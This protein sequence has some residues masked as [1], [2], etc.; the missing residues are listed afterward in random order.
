MSCFPPP[1]SKFIDNMH[2]VW[3]W[4]IVLTIHG[5]IESLSRSSVQIILQLHWYFEHHHLCSEKLSRLALWTGGI[6]VCMYECVG[7][8]ANYRRVRFVHCIRIL[9]QNMCK[10]ARRTFPI[11]TISN[12]D[13]RHGSR[14]WRVY[15]ILMGWDQEV[16][17]AIDRICVGQL[18][19]QLPLQLNWN[20]LRMI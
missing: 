20:W 9:M 13:R 19:L 3:L 11:N 15:W 5:N 10:K 1:V 17:A 7:S 16:R 6:C 8:W 18:Q 2:I 4:V 14:L 12:T